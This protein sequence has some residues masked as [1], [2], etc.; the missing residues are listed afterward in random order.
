MNN[1]EFEGAPNG[2][3]Q[4]MRWIFGYV[5]EVAETD[6]DGLEPSATSW[7]GAPRIA[8][9]ADTEGQGEQERH[10]QTRWGSVSFLLVGGGRDNIR[11]R[12]GICRRTQTQYHIVVSGCLAGSYTR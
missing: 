10:A 2:L 1:A 6:D 3:F 8:R 7:S 12:E 9:W 11:S 4:T 5:E